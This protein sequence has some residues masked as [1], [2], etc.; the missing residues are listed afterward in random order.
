MVEGA[1]IHVD[2][3]IEFIFYK[4]ILFLSNLKCRLFL[5]DKKRKKS[6]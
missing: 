4:K 6:N 2:C 3:F 1:N 5:L